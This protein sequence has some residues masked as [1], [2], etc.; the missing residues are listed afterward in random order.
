MKKLAIFGKGNEDDK[1]R[2]IGKESILDRKA[3]LS[4]IEAI[5][6]SVSNMEENV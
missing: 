4:R 5:L 6:S 2:I 3:S 1:I